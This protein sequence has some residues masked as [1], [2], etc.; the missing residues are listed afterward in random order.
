MRYNY[1]PTPTS[2]LRSAY[3]RYKSLLPNPRCWFLQ[4]RSE[5]NYNSSWVPAQYIV[6]MS[7]FQVDHLSRVKRSTPLGTSLFIILRILDIFIQYSILA[8]GLAD[9]IIDEF[10]LSTIPVDPTPTITDLSLRP[11][12]VLAMVTGATIK[13]IFWVS[14]ISNEEMPVSN[15]LKVSI[16]EIFFSSTNSILS[17]TKSPSS[18]VT[19]LL[20]LGYAFGWYIEIAAETE[21]KKFKD[22][23]QNRGK[24]YTKGLFRFARHIN[25]GAYLLRKSS[26]ALVCG[27]WKWGLAVATY[28]FLDFANRG[29]PVLGVYCDK[30]VRELSRAVITSKRS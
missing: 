9:P 2:F 19:T 18:G 22:N 21:R 27:G 30:R 14:Y 4:Y 20:L 25:Y 15:A 26:Q 29:I 24:L 3:S 13:S 11:L 10:H 7:G 28:H 6:K 5:R 1:G 8:Q 23:P 12:L 17:L 16:F